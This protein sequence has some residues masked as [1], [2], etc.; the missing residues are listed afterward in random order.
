MNVQEIIIDWLTSHGYDGLYNADG[1]CACKLGDLMPCGEPGIDCAPGYLAPC[2]GT[3]SE[4]C[5]GD[6]AFH[7]VAEKPAETNPLTRKRRTR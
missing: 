1:Q 5:D 2:P 6:C 4:T 7:I 3:A